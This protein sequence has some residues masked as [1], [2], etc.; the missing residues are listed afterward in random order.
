M[1]V[2][3]ALLLF[4]V[5]GSI[6]IEIRSRNRPKGG[7]GGVERRKTRKITDL[8]PLGEAVLKETQE[9][10]DRDRLATRDGLKFIIKMMQELYV[11]DMRRTL[12]VNELVEQMNIIQHKSLISWIELRPKLALFIALVILSLIVDEI[13]QPIMVYAF[14]QIGIKIP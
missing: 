9:M 8:E 5:V 6:V 12:K 2:F 1:N 7:Y 4:Y 11:S 13:R 14:S 10:I 3:L